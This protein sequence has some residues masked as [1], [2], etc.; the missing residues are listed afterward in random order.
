MLATLIIWLYSAA[1]FYIYGRGC[2]ILLKKVFHFQEQVDLPLPI[3]IVM[4][5]AILTTLAS[6]L[7]LVIPL[8]GLAAF[9]VLI[10]GLLISTTSGLF[11]NF[12][13]PSW[14]FLVWILFAVTAIT[15]LENSISAPINPDTALYH[16]QAIRWIESYRAVPGLANL[17]NRLA[18]NSS[19]L[20]LNASLSFAFLKLRSFHLTNSIFLLTVMVYFGTGFQNILRK[21]PAVSDVVK[22]VLFFLPLYF[23]SSSVSSPGTDLPAT[24][25]IWIILILVLEKVEKFGLD[26]D[27]YTV[28][29]FS[30][31]LFTASV[32]LSTIP[33]FLLSALVIAQLILKK[34]W[35]WIVYLSGIGVIVIL[36]W[37][38][39]NIILS[40]YIL[41]PVSQIDLFSFDWKNPLEAVDAT[42]T[43]ILW[44]ARFPNK[45]WED[46]VRLAP[47]QWIPLWFESLSFNQKLLT[48][49]AFLSPLFFF[50]QTLKGPIRK[51][52]AGYSIAFLT[53]YSG[54]LF[55]FLS[56]PDVRFGYG[57]L[58][59]SI[60]LGCTPFFLI[61]PLFEKPQLAFA[62]YS[63]VILAVL[64]QVYFLPM[65][66]DLKTLSQRLLLPADY[67]PSQADPCAIGSVTIYCRKVSG[68]C[69]YEHFPCIASLRPNVVLRGASL[70]DGF[71]ASPN[72]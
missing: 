68:Q 18:Y 11:K 42:R 32:K 65:N 51:F 2:V 30:L 54:L 57:F 46:Y 35:R 21:Q 33:L 71:R 59:L 66:V 48:G 38:L 41:F 37:V 50:I 3:I 39:R 1:L 26:F 25:L 53:G 58:L 13:F 47:T 6:F 8:A 19:W 69:N 17:Y 63:F 16:A 52:T 60:I 34:Q 12:R 64:F 28:A 70:Q 31:A 44:F 7:S 23:Y 9:L 29:I 43:G 4:G 24:L 49:L 15:V 61:R 22:S 14:H 62:R 5:V 27:L 20:V 45:N 36:P 40:G 67:L 10:G 55:W 56:A 72:P